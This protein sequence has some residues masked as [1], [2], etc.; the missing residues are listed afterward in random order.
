[1]VADELE[2]CIKLGIHDFLV[3]DDTFTVNK[4]RVIDICT[5]I[6]KRKLEIGWDIRTRVDTID[7]ETII[8]LKKAGCQGIHYGV[9]AGTDKILKI[10][11][12]GTTVNQARNIFRLTRKHKIPILAY[13]MIGNPNETI[14]DIST[15]FEVIKSLNPDYI[16]LTI[17]TPFPGTKIYF[18]GLR[19]GIIKKDYWRDFAQNP[20][21]GFVPPHWPEFFSR[22]Q[23]N[24]L[25]VKGYKSFYL[26]PSYILKGICSVG[27]LA[28][29]RKKAVAGLKVFG[30]K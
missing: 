1:Y 3:Y 5:E 19:N 8:H 13:F 18:D 4:K 12:K 15:T 2:Q 20:N 9:E 14:R 25:L 28:Q 11:N 30:M 29:F 27:S 23:L 6:V 24:N 7:E 16:H 17:L 10:L 21:T 22:E 26:R